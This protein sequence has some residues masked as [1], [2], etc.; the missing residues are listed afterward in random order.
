MTHRHILGWQKWIAH[1]GA[2]PEHLGTVVG[3]HND[4][5]ALATVHVMLHGCLHTS[6]VFFLKGSPF[7]CQPAPLFF[8][9]KVTK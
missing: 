3:R 6:N 4:T 7:D 1:I 2:S 8:K 5:E 9:D